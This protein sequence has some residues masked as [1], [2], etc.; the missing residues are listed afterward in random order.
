[1]PRIIVAHFFG[2]LLYTEVTANFFGTNM[3][4]HIIYYVN[5]RLF[6]HKYINI[7]AFL[8]KLFE[9]TFT[10]SNFPLFLSSISTFEITTTN[11]IYVTTW[12]DSEPRSSSAITAWRGGERERRLGGLPE[13][14]AERA[15]LEIIAP[16]GVRL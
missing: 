9:K 1:M 13:K 5:S 15:I 10:I 2:T 4:L 3:F 8:A 16:P 11:V 6:W 7:F 12:N 14:F